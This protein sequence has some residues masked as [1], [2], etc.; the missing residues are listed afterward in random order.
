MRQFSISVILFL[1]LLWSLFTFFMS[2][3][4]GKLTAGWAQITTHSESWDRNSFGQQERLSASPQE[5]TVWAQCPDTSRKLHLLWGLLS[6]TSPTTFIS[7]L[8]P[9]HSL[10][11]RFR[12]K[13]TNLLILVKSLNFVFTA[14]EI[15]KATSCGYPK[16]G[17]FPLRLPWSTFP[18]HSLMVAFTQGVGDL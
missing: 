11:D 4:T 10:K 17:T 8:S 5:G 7:T 18:R 13:V 2:C 3:F 15:P 9:G 12:L 14:R 1:S 16:I 6:S